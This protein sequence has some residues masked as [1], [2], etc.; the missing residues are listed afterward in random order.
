VNQTS[1]SRAPRNFPLHAILLGAYGPL[2]FLGANID[3]VQLKDGLRT[4]AVGVLG[5]ILV[6]LAARLLMKSWEKAGF[7]A[8]LAILLFLTYG[9]VYQLIEGT[10]LLGVVI[11]RHRYLAVLWMAV[12]GCGIW[13]IA[14]RVR[15]AASSTKIIN[16]MALVAVLMAVVQI[17]VFEVR[18]WAA[19]ARGA[20]TASESLNGTGTAAG[21]QPDVYYI[22]LDGYGSAGTVRTLEGCSNEDFLV[23]L[24]QLGFYV[25]EKSQSNYSQTE[26]SLTSSLNMAYLENLGIPLPPESNDRWP[27][28]PLLQWSLVRRNFEGR[29]YTIV[30]FETGYR[31]TEWMDA[32]VYL[33]PPAE[34]S[35]L[36][37]IMRQTTEFESAF[38]QTTLGAAAMDLVRVLPQQLTPVAPYPYTD[39]RDR[40]LHAIDSLEHPGD[41]PSPKF[42]FAHI[43]APHYPHVFLADG[44]ARPV[45][46][47]RTPESQ[48]TS[49]ANSSYAEGYCEEL[50]YLNQRMLGVLRAILATSDQP[51]IIIV[52]ADHGP[53]NA[54]PTD[55]MRILNA[56]YLP[57]SGNARLYE[58]ISPVNT[59]RVVLDQYFGTGYGLIEDRSEFSAY[60]T[61]YK[62]TPIP[63]Q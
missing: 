49:G 48:E 53:D 37:G 9:H 22:I 18:D 39:R 50:V 6:L 3:Q 7:A 28:R 30:A 52:Q 21:D 41:V 42:V 1:K 43:L 46:D 13:C 58:S 10:R 40:I 60:E 31:A 35:V 26:L 12:L 16:L 33:A 54:G 20:Q 38:I 57:G 8:S 27:L 15:W 47:V 5:A 4:L 25:A 2:A 14:R 55:R 34:P 24:T 17:A 56:Y 44:A 23:A 59:F 61:P 19:L 45:D 11:G 32:D 63:Q 29:R 62:F 36:L 51:P